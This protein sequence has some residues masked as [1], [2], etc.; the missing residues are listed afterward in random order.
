METV[1]KNDSFKVHHHITQFNSNIVILQGIQRL[2]FENKAE[3]EEFLDL[4]EKGIIMYNNP[5]DFK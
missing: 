2:K 3:T 4:L 1:I 5:R